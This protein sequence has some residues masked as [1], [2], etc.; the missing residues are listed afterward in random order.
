[1][2]ADNPNDA[3][4]AGIALGLSTAL[5][6]GMTYAAWKL[7]AK[8]G[9]PWLGAIGGFFLTSPIST[10]VYSVIAGNRPAIAVTRLP[11]ADRVEQIRITERV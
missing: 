2:S 8:H 9:H 10:G 4:R 11:P 6:L 1:M 7:G 3:A 5:H